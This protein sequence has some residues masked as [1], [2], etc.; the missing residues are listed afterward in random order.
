VGAVAHAEG[1]SPQHRAYRF[2]G[3]GT[4]MSGHPI[5][6]LSVALAVLVPAP[7]FGAAQAVVADP[8]GDTQ[9]SFDAKTDLVGAAVSW[10][11]V[12]TVQLTYAAAPASRAARIT[13]TEAAQREDDPTVT[14]CD[15]DFEERIAISVSSSEADLVVGGVEGTLRAP[16]VVTPTTT[17]FQFSSDALVRR[18]NVERHDPFVCLAVDADG[19]EA[20]GPFIG[21]HLKLTRA[22]VESGARAQLASRFG[23]H[24]GDA[25]RLRC[26]P[27]GVHREYIPET[28][29]D[30]YV[31]AYAECGFR[32]PASNRRVRFG[33]VAVY[34]D[35]G[36]P[37]AFTRYGHPYFRTLPAGTRECGTTDYSRSR[38]GLRWLL[39]PFPDSFGGASRT[40]WA[41]RVNCSTARRISSRTR[42]SGG[43]Y[44]CSVTRAGHEFRAVRCV[45]SRGRR[46]YI[47]SGA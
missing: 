31:R 46:V 20:L 40:V 43:G 39:P 25:A 34:L 32:A 2:A 19:D 30:D 28:Q 6:G 22:V 29:G 23:A 44:R 4:L 36:R 47:E 7:A 8:A 11:D 33:V 42:L 18:W 41:K 27:R 3:L 1:I 17:T 45:A 9:A 37:V 26:L 15:A 24:A 5:I 35:A 16:T 10:T 21:R 12:L 14:G 38:Y 13:I